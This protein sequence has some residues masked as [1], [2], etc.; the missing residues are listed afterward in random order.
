MNI[1]NGPDDSAT[2]YFQGKMTESLAGEMKPII[3]NSLSQVGAVKI[4]DDV[5]AKYRSIPFV[6]DIKANLTDYVTQK[7]MNGIFHYMAEEEAA[8][9]ENPAKQT[10]ELLKRVFG[11][12]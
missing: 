8:I 5:M 10:T 7:G 11:K 3:N 1:Y 2:R 12:K 9:R 6:P 4:Y